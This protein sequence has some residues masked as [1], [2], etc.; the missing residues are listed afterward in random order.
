MAAVVRR[1]LSVGLCCLIC[2]LILWYASA[3]LRKAFWGETQTP[4]VAD[5]QAQEEAPDVTQQPLQS[6]AATGQPLLRGLRATASGRCPFIRR[7]GCFSFS[8]APETASAS[9]LMSPMKTCLTP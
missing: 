9:M 6:D 1:V 8:A 5:A 2:G 3:P 4:A 7:S